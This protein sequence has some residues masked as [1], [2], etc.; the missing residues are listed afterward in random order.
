MAEKFGITGRQGLIEQLRRFVVEGGNIGDRNT[1]IQMIKNATG[2]GANP[3]PVA[4]ADAKPGIY[5]VFLDKLNSYAPTKARVVP[6]EL[7]AGTASR[8]RT[9]LARS[10]AHLHLTEHPNAVPTSWRC[11]GQ[12]E[13]WFCE[14]VSTQHARFAF[15]HGCD[16]PCYVAHEHNRHYAPIEP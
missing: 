4:W 15:G 2:L 9:L 12:P 8:L 6:T 10:E 11:P 14:S 7:N 5:A 1:A 13:A 3:N 16:C